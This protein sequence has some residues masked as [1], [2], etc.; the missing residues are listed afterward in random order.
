MTPLS[1]S[2]LLST[3]LDIFESRARATALN[4]ES[5]KPDYG[6]LKNVDERL[7]LYGWETNTGVKFVVGVDVR[8]RA[9]DKGS[10]RLSR[11]NGGLGVREGEAKVAFRAIQQAYVRLL[12][13]PFYDPDE[14]SPATG[15]GGK[16]IESR[17]FTDEIRRIGEQWRVGLTTL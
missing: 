7:S 15:R 3:T 13:N 14:H 6:L 12:Q 11:G 17:K 1:T 5:L 8:G 2:L 16:K 9:D 10:G 4:G